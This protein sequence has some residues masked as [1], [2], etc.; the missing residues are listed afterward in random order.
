MG[1]QRRKATPKCT[2]DGSDWQSSPCFL[3]LNRVRQLVR[4]VVDYIED[5]TW[6][7][8]R[9]YKIPTNAVT[10]KALSEPAAA[11]TTLDPL[12][13]PGMMNSV[14]VGLWDACRQRVE[15]G[16]WESGTANQKRR[17]HTGYAIKHFRGTFSASHSRWSHATC[18]WSDRSFLSTWLRRL[19]VPGFKLWLT[20]AFRR[21]YCFKFQKLWR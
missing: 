21:T 15:E 13:L 1:D 7:P 3:V 11:S 8:T 12:L 5:V 20:C 2:T 4:A 17:S 6:K 16:R 9:C 18:P 10:L 14:G 19:C